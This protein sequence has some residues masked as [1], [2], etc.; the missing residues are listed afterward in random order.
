MNGGTFEGRFGPL[1]DKYACLAK[2][3]VQVT[4]AET[5]IRNNLRTQWVEF[6]AAAAD[7]EAV[8]KRQKVAMKKSVQEDLSSFSAHVSDLRSR[9]YQLRS[10]NSPCVCC[11]VMA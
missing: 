5:Q 6:Q 7:A 8:L 10:C 11:L 1:E 3:D 2:Y 4:D 9:E